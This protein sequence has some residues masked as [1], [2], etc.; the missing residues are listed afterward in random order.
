MQSSDEDVDMPLLLLLG[1]SDVLRMEQQDDWALDGNSSLGWSAGER[2][3]FETTKSF[4]ECKDAVTA[5]DP[6]FGKRLSSSEVEATLKDWPT[7]EQASLGR[8][9]GSFEPLPSSYNSLS[10]VADASSPSSLQLPIPRMQVRE[11]EMTMA[12]RWWDADDDALAPLMKAGMGMQKKKPARV[13]K[14]LTSEE[15]D[16]VRD[17]CLV[18]RESLKTFADVHGARYARLF[19]EQYQ[20]ESEGGTRAISGLLLFGPSGTG[21]SLLA[22]AITSHI[23]GT[24]YTL[25]GAD[26][27]NGK[28][29]AQIINAL[30]DV[31]LAGE[32]PAVICNIGRVVNGETLGTRLARHR[33]TRSAVT[34]ADSG[35]YYKKSRAPLNLCHETN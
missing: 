18:P 28:A 22:Q 27:P 31:A 20:P 8:A 35:K 25:S 29:G 11:F 12:T 10:F 13:C 23:G 17:H 5:L 24:M 19:A 33:R 21:K 1:A 16:Y 4:L 2:D 7:D 6:G 34:A 26:L 3:R 14:D 15:H 30:F 32:K 9:D